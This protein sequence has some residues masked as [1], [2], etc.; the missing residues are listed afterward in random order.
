MTFLLAI[1]LERACK[2]EP[3]CLNLLEAFLRRILA[4]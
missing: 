3:E 4:A 1:S 2:V